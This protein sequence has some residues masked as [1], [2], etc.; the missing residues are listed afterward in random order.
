MV[1][2]KVFIIAIF[3]VVGM[4]AVSQYSL[5]RKLGFMKSVSDPSGSAMR[6]SQLYNSNED[7]QKQILDEQ[8][9]LDELKSA[10]TNSK[11]L[12]KL[13]QDDKNKYSIISGKTAV[14]GPGVL[15]TINHDLVASQIVDF[16]NAIKNIGAEAISLNGVRLIAQTPIKQFEGQNP[17]TMMII[18]NSDT[19]YDS[20]V[21]PGG[22]FDLIVNG[23][24]EKS[25]S[26]VLPKAQ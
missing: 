23:K 1:F 11:D 15:V 2:N 24:A 26:L 22:A 4:M 3:M 21:R 10:S 16:V 12:E 25:D 20:I 19:L 13:L 5:Y 14:T 7:L 6:I 18:G 8:T 17:Y 9:K